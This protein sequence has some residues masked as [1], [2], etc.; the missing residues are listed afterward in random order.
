MVYIQNAV[1][2]DVESVDDANRLFNYGLAARKTGS[3][4][5]NATSSRSHLVFALLIE[6][7]NR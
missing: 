3:T 4:D 2:K 5:M 7:T 6:S 1:E